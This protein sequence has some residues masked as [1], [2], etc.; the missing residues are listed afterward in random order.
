MEILQLLWS[1]RC[2]LVN[3]PHL[4]SPLKYSANFLQNNS[5]ACNAQKTQP[6][7]CLSRHSIATGVAQTTQKILLFYWCVHVTAATMLKIYNTPI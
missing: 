2:P 3:T 5:S 6:F 4:N 1:R 7:Y